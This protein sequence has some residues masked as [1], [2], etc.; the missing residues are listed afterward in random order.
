VVVLVSALVRWRKRRVLIARYG[1]AAVGS[2]RRPMRVRE[3]LP[4]VLMVAGFACAVIAFAQ[5]RIE[6]Q[7]TQGTVILTMD[8]SKSM[9]RTDV[10]PNRLSAAQDA[11]EAF[12]SRLPG[13]FQV[14]VVTF[15]DGATVAVEPTKDREEAG[16]ALESTASSQGTA[17]GDGMTASLDAIES[18]WA[19]G[20]R[21]PAAIVLLSDG[22]DTGSVVSPD[23][24]AARAQEQGIPVFTVTLGATE[25][26]S[27]ASADDDLMR[28]IADGTGGSTF[29]ALS[30][31]Q[32]T[33]V[34]QELGSTLSSDLHVGSS[35]WIFVLLGGVFALAA[36][37]VLFMPATPAEYRAA[38]KPGSSKRPAR[39]RS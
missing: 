17:I 37:V 3:R 27:T 39:S 35:A 16:A 20:G 21:G 33:D 6:R 19:Q 22:R 7:S 32:L 26:G 25:G 18:T 11:A 15:A 34:Y 14:G 28:R 30:A 1:A 4:I 2:R 38:P 31:D 24:A 12:L 10:A 9:Q 5:T 29:N 8:V 36:V 23:E 13:D